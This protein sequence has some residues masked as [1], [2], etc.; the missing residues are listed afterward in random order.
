MNHMDTLNSLKVAY[1]K[2]CSVLSKKQELI[3]FLA[4]ESVD[5]TLIGETWLI[6][7]HK[8][9]IPNYILHKTDRRNKPHGYIPAI[10]LM[11]LEDER[12]KCS[13]CG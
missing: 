1:W 9:K 2:A 8:F 3:Q 5:I 13:K 6:P 12:K 4:D 10:R 11:L 7:N